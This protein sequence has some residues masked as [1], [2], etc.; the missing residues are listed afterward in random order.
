MRD[1]EVTWGHRMS[2]EG[3]TCIFRATKTAGGGIWGVI[4]MVRTIENVSQATLEKEFP[5]GLINSPLIPQNEKLSEAARQ[6]LVHA[7]NAGASREV[8]TLLS[9]LYRPKS[10]LRAR[11][12][13]MLT[14]PTKEP[15]C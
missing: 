12:D 4:E 11:L 1:K 14:P 3:R 10:G 9:K 6:Y 13:A 2:R 7:A 8:V 15:S 5:F